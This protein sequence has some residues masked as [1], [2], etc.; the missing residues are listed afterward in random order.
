MVLFARGRPVTVCN[1]TCE[2]V[3]QYSFKS[4]SEQ[5]LKKA[6]RILQN[7]PWRHHTMNTC[8]GCCNISDSYKMFSRA[9]LKARLSTTQA[10]TPFVAV[11]WWRQIVLQACNELQNAATE[12]HEN[13]LANFSSKD[14]VCLQISYNEKEWIHDVSDLFFLETWKFRLISE[15]FNDALLTTY[16]VWH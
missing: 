5:Y 2:S 4:G 1:E 6:C 15:L 9:M 8:R 12:A 7:T 13:I 10:L 3:C 14:F 11:M 16:V